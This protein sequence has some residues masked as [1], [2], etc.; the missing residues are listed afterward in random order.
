VTETAMPVNFLTAAG[1]SLQGLTAQT[2]SLL[3]SLSLPSLRVSLSKR[4]SMGR[5]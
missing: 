3:L 2:H 1:L 5:K 4:F